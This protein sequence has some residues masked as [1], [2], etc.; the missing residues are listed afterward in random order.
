MWYIAGEGKGLVRGLLQFMAIS[1]ASAAGWLELWAFQ[2][3]KH[4]VERWNGSHD[5]LIWGLLNLN[6][7][8][9]WRCSVGRIWCLEASRLKWRK[10]FRSP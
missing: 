4:K 2:G 8:S 1:M 5:E 10:T 3:R 9:E 6:L 7:L